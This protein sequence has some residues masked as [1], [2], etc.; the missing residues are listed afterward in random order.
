MRRLACLAGFSLVLGLAEIGTSTAGAAR[1]GTWELTDTWIGQDRGVY[2]LVQTGT[3]VKWD[4]HAGDSKTWAHTF[5]GSL[6]G[7]YVIGHFKDKDGF[8][9]W[10]GSPATTGPRR[11]TR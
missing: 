8:S 6:Q 7:D 4:A 11:R 1:L 2:E 3:A 10:C 9:T 5:S